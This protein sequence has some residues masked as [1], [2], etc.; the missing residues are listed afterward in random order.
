M[1]TESTTFNFTESSV[2]RDPKRILSLL[3][4][5]QANAQGYGDLYDLGVETFL[6]NSWTKPTHYPVIIG[7]LIQEYG[8]DRVQFLLAEST[9]PETDSPPPEDIEKP[10]EGF[11]PALTSAL[12]SPYVWGILLVVLVVLI[13]GYLI[14]A[15]G[16]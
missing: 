4:K 13:G 8:Y 14:M 11:L 10:E 5:A 2:R 7:K 6:T 3:D 15:R 1:P 9:D 12:R 16:K